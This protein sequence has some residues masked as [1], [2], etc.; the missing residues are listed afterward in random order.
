MSRFGIKFN[1]P[2]PSAADVVSQELTVDWPGEATLTTDYDPATA[3]S[4][5]YT[6][7]LPATIN[8]GLVDVDAAGNR[9]DARTRSFSEVDDVAPALPGELSIGEKRQIT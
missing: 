7:E 8:V 1:L 2:G 4:N 3:V 9:S 6:G 5:E